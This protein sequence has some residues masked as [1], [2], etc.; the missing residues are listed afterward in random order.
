[1]NV[2]MWHKVMWACGPLCVV[3]WG[4]VLVHVLHC[5][6]MLLPNLVTTLPNLAMWCVHHCCPPPLRR[7]LHHCSCG[8]V[9]PRCVTAVTAVAGGAAR[10]TRLHNRGG[11][12]GA[13]GASHA[14]SMRSPCASQC[15]LQTAAGRLCSWCSARI[16]SLRPAAAPSFFAAFTAASTA[17]ATLRA[18]AVHDFWSCYC[19]HCQKN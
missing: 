18:L 9:L 15:R 4:S 10:R 12:E 7:L 5:P 2:D 14:H 11:D 13:C 19:P 16:T 3:L 8:A 17:C 6:H 1:M